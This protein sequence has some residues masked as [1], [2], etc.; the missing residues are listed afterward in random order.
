MWWIFHLTK[1][2]CLDNDRVGRETAMQ[3][4]RKYAYKGY[5]AINEPPQGKDF[6][7]DLQA[8]KAQIRAEKGIKNRERNV[9]I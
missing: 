2:F 1:A 9:I 5:T 3:M 7:E 4:A 6:N 8:L